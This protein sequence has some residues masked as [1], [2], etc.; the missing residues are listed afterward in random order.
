MG[1]LERLRDRDRGTARRR[2]LPLLRARSLWTLARSY[3]LQSCWCKL[4]VWHLR[5]RGSRMQGQGRGSLLLRQ[6][7]WLEP[8]RAE[9]VSTD[10][11]AAAAISTSACAASRCRMRHTQLTRQILRMRQNAARTAA[12]RTHAA[13]LLIAFG[14]C[15][16]THNADETRKS[17]C[18]GKQWNRK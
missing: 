9:D 2:L 13:H 1:E 6:H 15:T 12:A 4:R 10:A 18:K 5:H 7:A 14:R 16:S 11:A 3:L 8:V 17:R